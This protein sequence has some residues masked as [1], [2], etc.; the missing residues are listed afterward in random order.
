MKNVK[1][2]FLTLVVSVLGFGLCKADD[3]G[4][5]QD[6]EVSDESSGRSL[7]LATANH[8]AGM[9]SLQMSCIV[10]KY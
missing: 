1:I 6:N 2:V 7:S 5:Y 9:F 4:N 10:I 3:Y 8:P